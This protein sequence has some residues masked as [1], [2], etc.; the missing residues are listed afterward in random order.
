[1]S[2][3][4]LSK[5]FASIFVLFV[6][7]FIGEGLSCSTPFLEMINPIN[8]ILL[9]MLYGFGALITRELTLR[10][11]TKSYAFLTLIFLG[12]AYG[13][14]EEGLFLMSF[15]NPEWGDLG[16]FQYYGRVMGVN[17]TW[18]VFLAIFHMVFSIIVP[19]VFAHFT[20]P[21]IKE[22]KWLPN[23]LLIIFI[24]LFFL[25]G[26]VWIFFVYTDF[27]YLPGILEY[28]L[29]LFVTILLI[30]LARF[31]PNNFLEDQN[32][33]FLSSDSTYSTQESYP[34]PTNENKSTKNLFLFSGS[35]FIASF[36]W[37]LFFFIGGYLFSSNKVHPTIP[38]FFQIGLT[39]LLLALLILSIRNKTP[40]NSVLLF[41]S[42]L[43]AYSFLYFFHLLIAD[44]ISKIAYGILGMGLVFLVFLLHYIFSKKSE[45]IAG[46]TPTIITDE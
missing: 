32:R 1:M 26:G 34:T 29:C 11:Q 6:S 19:I 25:G 12:L 28:L 20:F 18:A 45:N 40:N 24:V 23:Y 36:L 16:D 43:G 2:K 39:L 46:V 41:F 27:G 13:C 9:M 30:L 10:W 38:I 21:T 14:I 37:G 22:E 4:T 17:W 44:L 33:R 5:F 42:M 7:P 35:L 31:V 15:F 3:E 8:F